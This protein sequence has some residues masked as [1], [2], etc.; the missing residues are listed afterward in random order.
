MNIKEKQIKILA[1]AIYEIRVLLAHK[2]EEKTSE[3]FAASLAYALHNDAEAI[4]ED[5]H[6]DFKI[7][8][9][10][11]RL[12]N[13]AHRYEEVQYFNALFQKYKN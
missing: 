10:L 8:N 9:T 12:D 5:R 2:L 13:L 7:E 3:G 6:E 4:L 1:Q 11:K